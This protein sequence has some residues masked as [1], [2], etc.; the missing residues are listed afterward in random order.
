MDLFGVVSVISILSW[1]ECRRLVAASKYCSGDVKW[2]DIT[3]ST[4]FTLCGPFRL[5][6]LPVLDNFVFLDLFF[7][8]HGFRILIQN[9]D[10]LIDKCFLCDWRGDFPRR[11]PKLQENPLIKNHVK[12]AYLWTD[13]SAFGLSFELDGAPSVV[14]L[15]GTPRGATFKCVA[16]ISSDLTNKWTSSESST[17]DTWELS[18]SVVWLLTSKSI[19]SKVHSSV[20]ISKKT[21]IKINDTRQEIDN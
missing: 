12:K 10:V 8:F 15:S 7:H 1:I 9:L 4:A 6:L 18:I 16:V 20:L 17:D 11:D 19:S 13:P 3:A 14:V 2:G 5:E 21:W